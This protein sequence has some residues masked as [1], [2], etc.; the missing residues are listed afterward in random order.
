M[1]GEGSS[2]ALCW[3]CAG[4]EAAGG[5]W[6]CYLL[7]PLW[8][9]QPEE[10]CLLLGRLRRDPKKRAH[11]AACT[12]TACPQP[13]LAHSH[14]GL[15]ALSPAH[16]ALHSLYLAQYHCCSRV[17]TGWIR[18]GGVLASLFG[19]YYVGA[20]LDDAEG[21]HP[22]HLYT[23]T[24]IGRLLLSAA[25]TALVAARQCEPALLWLAAAN[26]ASSALLW[27]AARRRAAAEQAL[28][29]Q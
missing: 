9:P 11:P 27:R 22:R 25:F 2:L 26:A 12:A 5:W 19:C 24:I 14:A 15:C 23:S 6:C 8:L 1:P 13:P 17:P 28:A 7:Q 16:P 20:A 4:L 29:D 3:P 18:V 21:R 10:M